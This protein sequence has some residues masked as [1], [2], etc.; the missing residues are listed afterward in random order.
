MSWIRLPLAL[1]LVFSPLSGALS[2]CGGDPTPPPPNECDTVLVTITPEGVAS[3]INNRN[4]SIVF[5]VFI[6]AYSC[7]S[8]G[9]TDTGEYLNQKLGAGQ[10]GTYSP[11]IPADAC[12]DQFCEPAIYEASVEVNVTSLGCSLGAGAGATG[13][14]DNGTD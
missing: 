2:D 9:C 12:T 6:K 8:A 13:S 1:G 10:A 3:V 5:D 11:N 14:T 7:T 4:D